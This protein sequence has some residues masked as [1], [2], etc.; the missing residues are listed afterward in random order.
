[1]AIER[2]LVIIK[3]DAVQM[4]FITEIEAEYSAVGLSIIQRQ[5]KTFTR[6]EAGEFYQ[7]HRGKF[8]FTGLILAMSS[9]PSISLIL[10]GEN[11]IK[12]VRIL[13]GATNPAEAVPG[14]IRYKYRSA[15]GPFNT[16]HGSDSMEEFE[17][18]RKVIFPHDNYEVK[19]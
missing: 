8:Y 11:A 17:R 4:G 1:M 19:M 12:V 13:N 18:E 3:P 10:E 14:T 9:G 7:T 16:V 5:I 2:T 15:G 6:D